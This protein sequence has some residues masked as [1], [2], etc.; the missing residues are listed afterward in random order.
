MLKKLIIFKLLKNH[1]GFKDA[2]SLYI[3]ILK[4]KEII[5]LPNLKRNVFLRK[6]TKDLETFEEIFFTNLYNTPLNFEPLSIIDAGANVGLASLFF[7]M[8]YPKSS[9][10][11]IEIEKNNA[12]MILKNTNGLT[13]F[14]LALKALSNKKSYYKVVDPYNA[15]NSFQM[16]EVEAEEDSDIESITLDE[17]LGLKKW[18][19]IDILKIDIEGAEKELFEKNYENW[20]PK[21]KVIMVETH[22]R[23]MP[24]CSYTVMNT[25]NKYNFILYTTTEGTLIYYNMDYINKQ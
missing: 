17:I 11:A 25:I 9:V 22:D 14:E 13:D 24:K 8:K 23:M 12:E 18:D 19:T 5:Y 7:K 20:L 3:G 2:F 4:L 21:V 15:T 10:F 1:F 6:N 16:K